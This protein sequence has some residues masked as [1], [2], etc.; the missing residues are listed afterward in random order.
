MT[1]K[2]TGLSEQPYIAAFSL[3]LVVLLLACAKSKEPLSASVPA[4][5]QEFLNKYFEAWRSKDIATL[6]AFS[7]YLS[8]EDRSKLPQSSLEIWRESKNKLVTEHFERVS[9]EFGDFK[10]YEV[11]R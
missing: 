1:K 9:R 8:P 7:F 3:F 5:C 2:Q 6:Q 10:G 11:L 4:D